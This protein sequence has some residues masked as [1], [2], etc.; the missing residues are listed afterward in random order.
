[1]KEGVRQL[2]QQSSSVR[3]AAIVIGVL[4]ILCAIWIFYTVPSSNIAGLICGAVVLLLGIEALVAAVRR[5]PSLLS[6]IGLLP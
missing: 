6:R 3:I 5:R 4:F 2:E 1:M